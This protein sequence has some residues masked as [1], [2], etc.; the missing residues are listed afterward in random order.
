MANNDAPNYVD[1]QELAARLATG[2]DEENG[3]GWGLP[4][5]LGGVGGGILGFLAALAGKRFF[6][7]R[8][9]AKDKKAVEALARS[10]KTLTGLN[11][12][13]SGKTVSEYVRTLNPEQL[14]IIAKTNQ[15][16]ANNKVKLYENNLEAAKNNLRHYYFK[17]LYG[18]RAYQNAPN[19]PSWEG[20]ID[21]LI[22]RDIRSERRLTRGNKAL[23]ATRKAAAQASAR[24][25]FDMEQRR[26]AE[27]NMSFAERYLR[28]RIAENRRIAD[29]PPAERNLRE[30]IEDARRISNQSP[31]ERYLRERKE[32]AL[33]EGYLAPA[34]RDLR[35]RI[36]EE[37]LRAFQQAME[38][39][40]PWF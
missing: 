13:P 37:K 14:E 29:L 7:G 9:V 39:E 10:I 8:Q 30:R 4:L 15:K 1:D 11:T 3:G 28:Q 32:K 16:W 40:E 6:R 36:E 5:S 21:K 2:L 18:T 35:Q 23:Q 17:D 19:D 24:S 34:E 25:M 27:D 31:A 20:Y 33:R 38:D 12:D 22:D 26:I